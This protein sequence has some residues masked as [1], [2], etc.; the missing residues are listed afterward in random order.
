MYLLN[1]ITKRFAVCYASLFDNEMKHEVVEAL[2]W[3]QAITRHS[4][5]QSNED[6]DDIREWLD[7]MPDDYE[8]ALEF[9]FDCDL[10]ISAIEV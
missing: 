4:S 10:L 3:S 7:D 6:D 5:F 8:K 9:F 1:P 2:D